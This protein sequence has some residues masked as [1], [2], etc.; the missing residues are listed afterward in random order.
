MEAEVKELVRQECEKAV[1]S[2]IAK[3]SGTHRLKLLPDDGKA[4]RRRKQRRPVPT[5][6]L[7]VDKQPMGGD[8][9]RLLVEESGDSA[10]ET[11][12]NSSSLTISSHSSVH[13]VASSTRTLP[14][15]PPNSGRSELE[16]NE[17]ETYHTPH[18][19]DTAPI[20]RT[21]PRLSTTS[22]VETT[23]VD[24]RN[25]ASSG[26]SIWQLV[27]KA[28]RKLSA[29]NHT[30]NRLPPTD[31]ATARSHPRPLARCPEEWK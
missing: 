31:K 28:R 24:G 1:A 27:G 15:Q 26:G 21:E 8:H 2:A 3:L 14:Q 16:A 30:T 4:A 20:H 18:Q 17:L 5:P 29:D 22:L 11:A 25:G 19:S 13:G 10:V 9:P 7:V 12:T 23:S 6:Q